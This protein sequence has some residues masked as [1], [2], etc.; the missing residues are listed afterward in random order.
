VTEVQTVLGP[1]PVDEL[2]VTLPHEHLALDEY[3]FLGHHIDAVLSDVDLAVEEA[4]RY[5]DAGGRTIV[6]VTTKDLG[7]RPEFLVE[8]ATRTG[9]HV[10]MG[11]GRYIEPSYEPEIWRRSVD[12]IADEFVD[13][14]ERGIDGV[15]AAVIGEIGVGTYHISPAEE[16]VHRAA[17]RAHRRTGAPIT[18]HAALSPVGLDQLDLFEEEG[19][20]LRR[21]AIG[22]CDT[23]GEIDHLEAIAVRGAFVE[24]DLIH[25]ISDWETKRQVR[26]VTE[27]ISRG[28]LEQVLLSQDVC[29]RSHL[30]AYGGTGYANLLIAFVPE[31][32]GAGLSDEQVD[33]LLV[34][35]PRRLLTG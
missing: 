31:L 7:R 3:R 21:V 17:A 29:A 27:L 26:L 20:D 18:T 34:R 24:F 30:V 9:L 35:N 25:G 4:E 33:A 2:G 19:V 8:V 12:D 22:H 32:R 14:L 28:Y 16:R 5:R 13:D 6:E 1:V 11:T 15:R 10:L 23:Y